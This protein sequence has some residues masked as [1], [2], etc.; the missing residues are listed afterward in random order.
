MPH[1]PQIENDG[2]KLIHACVRHAYGEYLRMQVFAGCWLL[3]RYRTHRIAHG[4]LGLAL[5]LTSRPEHTAALQA[6][7]GIDSC[8]DGINLTSSSA[9]ARQVGK[10][11]S[12]DRDGFLENIKYFL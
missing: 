1:I 6:R 3:T 4:G 7:G 2:H 10:F 9:A 8:K 12:S 5:Y 11:E